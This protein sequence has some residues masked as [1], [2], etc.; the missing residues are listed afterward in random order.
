M[1]PGLKQ[2][3]ERLGLAQSVVGMDASQIRFVTAPTEPYPPNHNRVQWAPD[4]D[5]LWKS[6]HDDAPLPGNE[7]PPGPKAGP[8]PAATTGPSLRCGPTRSPLHVINASGVSGRGRQA[9]GD[10]GIQGFHTTPTTT[11]TSLKTGVIV[12]YSSLNLQSARTV[13]AAFP[14]ATMVMDQSAGDFMRVTLGAGSPYVVEVPNRRGTAPL[15]KPNG[16]GATPTPAVTI[17]ART[18]DSNVCKA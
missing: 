1:D 3:G 5:A 16:T 14:G 2:I 12:G 4:A 10:L 11:A 13:A 17:R 6:I 7:P 8:N 15:S 9:A 18:A